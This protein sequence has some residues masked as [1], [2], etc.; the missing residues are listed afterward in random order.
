LY[1][2]ELAQHIADKSLRAVN[3]H[4]PESTLLFM[5]CQ[6]FTTKTPEMPNI[7]QTKNYY[8]CSDSI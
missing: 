6:L 4:V 3:L 5:I 7:I 2:E 8:F 1:P